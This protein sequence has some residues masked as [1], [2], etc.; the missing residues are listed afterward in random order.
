VLFDS[1]TPL[2]TTGNTSLDSATKTL[3]KKTLR[4]KL[5]YY[6]VNLLRGTTP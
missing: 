1:I 5:V 4:V 2:E 3:W 6:K